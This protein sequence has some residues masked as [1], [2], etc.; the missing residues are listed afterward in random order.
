[1]FILHAIDVNNQQYRASCDPY[2]VPTLLT[3]H[4]PVLAEDYIGIVK[5]K[6]RALECEA[7]VFLLVRPILFNIPFE[8]HRYTK[9]ITHIAMR[10]PKRAFRVTEPIE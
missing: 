4:D 2:G 8:P 5:N 1:M 10:R 3:S 9:C 7:V 6:C